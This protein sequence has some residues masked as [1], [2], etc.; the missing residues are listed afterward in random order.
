MHPLGLRVER[1]RLIINI[2]ELVDRAISIYFICSARS[3]EQMFKTGVYLS[4]YVCMYVCM[5]VSNG[6]SYFF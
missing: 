6:H 1:V 2:N 4:V 5:Y 3:A